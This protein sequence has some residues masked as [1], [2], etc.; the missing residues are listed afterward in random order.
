MPGQR[1]RNELV[2]LCHMPFTGAV[3]VGGAS[4]RFGSPKA[5]A[6]F[7]GEALVDRARRLLGDVCEEVL[8]VGKTSDELPVAV[9]DAGTDSRAPIFG[10]IAA[11][12]AARYDVVVA[13]PVD[14]P[15]ITPAALRA[16]GEAVA[17]PSPRIPLPG[18]YPRS[19]LP[20]LEERVRRGELSLRGVNGT[21]LALPKGLLVDVDTREALVELEELR[22]KSDTG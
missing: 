15:L 3:L 22:L 12:R 6:R 19:L 20:R 2:T 18:A 13:L 5:L 8:V 4:S 7:R 1:G 16:L 11:L 10:L 17:V 21:T 14:V 9:L